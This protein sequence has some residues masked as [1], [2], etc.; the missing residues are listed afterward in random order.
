MVLLFTTQR[1]SYLTGFPSPGLDPDPGFA[2]MTVHSVMPDL[3]SLPRE[4]SLVVILLW[5]LPRT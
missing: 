4:V 3:I 1:L 5:G 2:G